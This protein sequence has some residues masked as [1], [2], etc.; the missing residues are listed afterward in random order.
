M[1]KKSTL[2]AVMATAAVLLGACADYDRWAEATN[3]KISDGYTGLVMGKQRVEIDKSVPQSA[4]IR[5]AYRIGEGVGLPGRASSRFYNKLAGDVTYA[6]SCR[7]FLMFKVAIYNQDRALI[8]TENVIIQ[9][10]EAND[11]ALINK[12][13]L[14]DPNRSRSASVGLLKVK[15]FQC[16]N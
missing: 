8:S 3:H 5:L 10:Y 12:D 11:K 2:G 7:R 9:G 14:T 4:H 13:V 6:K 15:D 16:L 1:L